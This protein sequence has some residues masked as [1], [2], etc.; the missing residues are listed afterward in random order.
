MFPD[1]Y[2][3]NIFRPPSE[4]YSL[5]LQAT[6]GC[7][8]DR[9]SFCT[10]FKG[11]QFRI[12]SFEEIEKDVSKIR[13]L[14]RGVQKIFLADANALCMP[15]ED[16]VRILKFLYASF[17]SLERV[18]IYGGPIDIKKKTVE[19]L[20]RL[21]EAGLDLVYFGLESGSDE[22]LKKVKK[23]ATSKTMVE[24]AEKIRTAGLKLSSIFILGLGGR[25]LSAVHARETAR[26]LSAQEP[27]Y[28]AA[29]TLMVN[30]GSD[31]EKDVRE[32]HLTLLS[33]EEA[34]RELRTIV[35]GLELE[36]TLFRTNHASN[37]AGIGGKLPGDKG[38]IL[39]QID[40][41]L[42]Q[43]CFKDEAFRRL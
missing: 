12:K 23:G 42:K 3:G 20:I 1:I 24:C 37:Y 31:I 35:E 10:A 19:E 18:S 36:N 17:S 28:A 11:K 13:P 15:A 14:V 30:P 38:R 41:A 26:V 34:L 43:G 40:I 4:A 29:L 32:G 6:I 16:L 22:V 39:E 27:D 7:S 33:P 25:E 5:I 9:C 21:R 2:E 8:W